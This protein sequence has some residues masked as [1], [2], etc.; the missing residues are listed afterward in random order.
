[1]AKIDYPTQ[2]QRKAEKD[3][4]WRKVKAHLQATRQPV[5]EVCG[6]WE[7]WDAIHAHHVEFGRGNRDHGG[8]IQ[9]LCQ[10]HHREAHGH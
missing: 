3:K 4:H 7:G 9:L 8:E 1:M 10:K 6:K 2:R 5:C